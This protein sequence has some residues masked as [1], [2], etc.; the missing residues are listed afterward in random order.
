MEFTLSHSS[1]LSR[2]TMGY[3][4]SPASQAEIAYSIKR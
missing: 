2:F 3:F 4:L 1:A